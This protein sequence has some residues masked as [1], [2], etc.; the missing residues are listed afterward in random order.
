MLKDKG[1]LYSLVAHIIVLILMLFKV[2]FYPEEAYDLSQA[3]RVDMV[4]LPDKIDPQEIPINEVSPKTELAKEEPEPI[5]KNEKKETAA[6]SVENKEQQKDEEAIRLSKATEQKKKDKELAKKKEAEIKNKQ[7]EA[8]NKLKKLNALEKIKNDVKNESESKQTGNG[9]I[10]K[11]RVISAGTVLTG[12]DK[13]QSESYLSQLDLK[14]KSHW[15]LPQWLIGKS[16]RSRILVKFDQNGQLLTK[17][18]V[19]SSGNPTYDEY[20]LLAVEKSTP[21]PS[22]P[23]KFVEV[24]KSD[25]VVIG[26]PD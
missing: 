26:F 1:F 5:K 21:F 17:K 23:E 3:I 11:G 12:V 20:C 19:Q 16:L 24:Y 13:I 2:V 15:A 14:I 7:K 4:G 6:D 9:K 25:G 10:Y 22:V 18:I 8:L